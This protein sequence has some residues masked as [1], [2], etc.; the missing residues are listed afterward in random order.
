MGARCVVANITSAARY[1]YVLRRAID[2]FGRFYNQ[3][4]LRKQLSQLLTHKY[5]WCRKASHH[6][7]SSR[8]I[9]MIKRTLLLALLLTS[10]VPSVSAQTRQN[11]P[12]AN[13][14][15]SAIEAANR[16]FIEAFNRGDAASVA[17]MYTTDAR[18]LPPD[19]RMLEGRQNIQM[20]WLGLINTGFQIT[21][22]ETLT[23]EAQGNLAS[24]IGRYTIS[25]R[26]NGQVVTY[27]GKYVV[28]WRRQSG[29]WRLA[30]D[31]W[32]SDAPA[33]NQ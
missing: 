5:S 18:L 32:N 31:I 20:F 6:H 23:V 7:R 4:Q 25:N 27:T 17:A 9:L 26:V 11:N 22:L 14:P 30:A 1:I 15:R 33:S 12:A 16:R 10:T 2:L 13:N 28:V 24:E 8:K 19:N 3:R 29:R 21:R